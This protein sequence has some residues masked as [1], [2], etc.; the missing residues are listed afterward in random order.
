MTIPDVGCIGLIYP[1]EQDLSR[2]FTLMQPSLLRGLHRPAS[3]A[4]KLTELEVRSRAPVVEDFLPVDLRLCAIEVRPQD[5][6]QEVCK[7]PPHPQ[8][9]AKLHGC[10][11]SMSFTPS[12]W[13]C[14]SES[15]QM[16]HLNRCKLHWVTASREWE[17]ENQHGCRLSSPKS[18]ALQPICW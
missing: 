6:H 16:H 8:C 9:E 12:S 18:A 11:D 15:F 14:K 5:G 3:K 13:T 2:L 4:L 1:P 7:Q 10:M 17:L